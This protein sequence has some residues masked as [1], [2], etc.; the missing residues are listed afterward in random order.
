MD[1]ERIRAL[2]QEVLAKLRGPSAPGEAPDLESRVAALEGA[3]RGL[4]AG[5]TAAPAAVAVAVA[6]PATAVAHPALRLLD[7]PAGHDHCVLEPD[8]PCCRS[9]RCRSFGY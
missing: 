1:E 9:G 6:T 7:V 3:L 2:T 5:A 4:Q 8:K